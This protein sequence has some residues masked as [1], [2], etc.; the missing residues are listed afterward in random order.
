MLTKDIQ[1]ELKVSYM[2]ETSPSRFCFNILNL[3]LF[4][5]IVHKSPVETKALQSERHVT[6]LRHKGGA[7]RIYPVC[8]AARVLASLCANKVYRQPNRL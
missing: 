8:L 4:P 2:M 7:I 1:S 6:A 3:L 5:L